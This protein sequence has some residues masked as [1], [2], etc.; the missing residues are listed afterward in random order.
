MR[1][2]GETLGKLH[3]TAKGDLNTSKEAVAKLAAPLRNSW[4]RTAAGSE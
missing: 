2:A 4:T 1:L 3:E